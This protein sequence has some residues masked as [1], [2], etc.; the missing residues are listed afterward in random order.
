MLRAVIL[1]HLLFTSQLTPWWLWSSVTFVPRGSFS[2]L[3]QV[4]ELHTD[5]VEEGRGSPSEQDKPRAMSGTLKSRDFFLFALLL[6][7]PI[8]LPASHHL[9]LLLG[10]GLALGKSLD[11]RRALGSTTP[12]FHSLHSCRSSGLVLHT[13]SSS[14]HAS[15]RVWLHLQEAQCFLM[16]NLVLK[17]KKEDPMGNAVWAAVVPSEAWIPFKK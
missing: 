3:F 15:H 4:G 6:Y 14:L 7:L 1:T 8:R 16:H 13:P 9:G 12:Q 5:G 2:R 11:R 10:S 17:G